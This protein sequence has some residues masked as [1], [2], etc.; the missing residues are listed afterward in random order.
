MEIYYP[1]GMLYIGPHVSIAESIAL[2]VERAHSLGATGF[3][4]FS[5]NQ[6][7]WKSPALKEDEVRAFRNNMESFGYSPCCVLP[8]AGYLINPASPD[9]VLREKSLALFLDEV[10]RLTLLGLKS[11]NIHPGA[12]KEGEKKEGIERSAKMI[13]A[14]LERFPDFRV[15]IENTAGAGTIIGSTIE[16][17][18]ALLDNIPHNER[19]G[20]TLDTAHL[21]GAGYDVKNDINSILDRF[22]S[23]FGKDKLYGMHLNDSKVPL[24]SNKDRHENIGKGLIGKEAFIEIAKRPEVQDIPLIL[25]TPDSSL[26][27]AEIR[28]LLNV[29]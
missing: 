24:A 28:E 23:I 5:K 1:S 16:E 19:V 2:S 21:Y 18:E 13:D 6:R 27:E 4:L 12:Y 9:P 10:E 15:A 7:M 3:A 22:F 26:W 14:V 11:I 29:Q 17:L 20:F 25:E 8:H